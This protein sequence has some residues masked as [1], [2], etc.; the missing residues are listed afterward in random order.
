[1]FKRPHYNKKHIAHCKPIIMEDFQYDFC[2]V[3]FIQEFTPYKKMHD[4]S[5]NKHAFYACVTPRDNI[6]SAP[7]NIFN[8]VYTPS[9]IYNCIKKY[10][11]NNHKFL[12]DIPDNIS[13]LLNSAT[14]FS[15][16]QLMCDELLSKIEWDEIILGE[17]I[18]VKYLYQQMTN[19]FKNNV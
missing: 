11:V 12:M 2:S 9:A 15:I 3:W 14:S 16:Y 19:L 8:T 1:M 6:Q 4:V 13:R 17:N 10:D 18:N 5:Y 7:A